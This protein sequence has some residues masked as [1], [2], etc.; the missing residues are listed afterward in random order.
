MSIYLVMGWFRINSKFS[1]YFSLWW[2]WKLY[3]KITAI[4][5]Q[6]AVDMMTSSNGNIFRVTGPLCGEF[7]SH[8]WIPEQRIV[9]RSFGVFF[10][11]CL[12]KRL[13]KQSWGCWFRTPSPSPW[14]HCDRLREIYWTSSIPC[15]SL[16]LSIQYVTFILFEC[17][18]TPNN[19]NVL[20]EVI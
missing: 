3:F 12:N 14:R 19:T 13:N 5:L 7:T 17:I 9:T 20:K 15:H 2:I 11:L 10:L 6:V 4:Y 1:S 18:L 16:H 8:R